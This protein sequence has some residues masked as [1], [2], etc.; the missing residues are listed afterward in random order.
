MKLPSNVKPKNGIWK[1]IPFLATKTA[2]GIYPNVYL[3]VNIYNNLK[4]EHP[5]PLYVGLMIHEEEHIKRQRNKPILW[6]L[7]YVFNSKFRFEEEIAAD[8]PRIIYLKSKNIQFNI[9]HR[10]KELS[11]WL[12]LWPENYTLT[13]KRLMKIIK[14]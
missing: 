5:N 13:K 9:D 8:I 10:A 4:S 14:S 12:Y 2:H 3:P 6:I 7:K 1:I 11:G